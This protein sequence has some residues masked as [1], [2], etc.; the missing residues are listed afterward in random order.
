MKRRLPVAPFVA[1]AVAF[2]IGALVVVF[3]RS[4]SAA[5]RDARSRLVGQPA[6]ILAGDTIDGGTFD[7]A[8][9]RGRW[10]VVN[11]MAS[12]CT[13]CRQEQTEL[14]AFSNRHAQAADAEVVAVLV[15]DTPDAVAEF[16]AKYGQAGPAVLDPDGQAYVDFGVVKVPETYLVD[17]DGIVVAKVN[18]AVS[19]DGLDGA[20]AG[21]A[22]ARAGGGG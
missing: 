17:P 15:N 21:L 2:V 22:Q 20:L 16:F 4:D 19:A 12:W 1:L 3:A 6:P 5:D 18:G 13:P 14:V 10:V 7:L 9:R 8:G 11:F